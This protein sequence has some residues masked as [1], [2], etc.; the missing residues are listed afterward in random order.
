[1]SNAPTKLVSG[2]SECTPR[3]RFAALSI[4]ISSSLPEPHSLH[5]AL[6]LTSQTTCMRFAPTTDSILRIQRRLL[7]RCRRDLQR[8]SSALPRH[9]SS[10]ASS[11]S[12]TP[13][14][15]SPRTFK[16]REDSDDEEESRI[17]FADGGSKDRLDP[18]DDEDGRLED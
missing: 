3:R 13:L 9:L 12:G 5:P 7:C 18:N 10:A 2:S 1:M 11:A 4:D 14:T 15:G 8:A 17:V 6:C 16:S